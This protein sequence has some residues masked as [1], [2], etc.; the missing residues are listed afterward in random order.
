MDIDIHLKFE[1]GLATRVDG[2]SDGAGCG[3]IL[4]FQFRLS[5]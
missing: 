4:R 2:G 1:S 5:N 3:L